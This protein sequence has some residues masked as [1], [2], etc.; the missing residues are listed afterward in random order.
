M[1]AHNRRELT[2][3][4]LRSLS[5]VPEE[6]VVNTVLLDDGS[7]D[8]TGD[9]VRAAFPDTIVLT[10]DGNAFWNGG[11][12][13][14]WN[15]ALSLGVDGY[16]W[17]NDDVALDGDALTRL[18]AAWQAHDR[19]AAVILVG[20]T[21]DEQGRL[22]YGGMR[23][24][25]SPF[26]FRFDRLSLSETS[27]L[28]D[29]FNGNIVLV[30]HAVVVR[31]GLND[32][33][34]LHTLGDIDYGLRAKKAGALI[35]QLPGTLGVCESNPPIDLRRMTLFQR[36]RHMTSHRGIP[37]RNWWRVT[38]RHSGFWLPLHFLL[39]YRQVIWPKRRKG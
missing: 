32:P 22:T 2:L 39:A 34:F 28:A 16:L 30:S 14:S 7:S 15:R 24:V 33:G 35:V 38:Q 29:T 3:R 20:A 19:D 10:A 26:A 4:A 5:D 6:L 9:A 12:H 25:H 36:W 8:G 23:Q 11:M 21:R 18:H 37:P 31:I 1:A 17:L 13:Q 27:Q